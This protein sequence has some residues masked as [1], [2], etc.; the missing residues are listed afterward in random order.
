M[1]AR[2]AKEN[3]VQVILDMGGRS[4]PISDELI[5]LCDIISP[6][7]TEV[8]RLFVSMPGEESPQAEETKAHE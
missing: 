2:C 7:E 3:N 8:A 5:R 1:A 4:D 6:N